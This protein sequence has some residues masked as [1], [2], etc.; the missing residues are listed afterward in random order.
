[1]SSPARKGRIIVTCGPSYEPIDQVR[2][3][4][5]LSTGKLGILLANRLA[6]SGWD[7]ACLK[8]EAATCPDALVGA[9]RITFSTNDDL[10]KR[11]TQLP[12]RN[13]VSAIFHSAALCDFK[14]KQVAGA[15]RSPETP[16]KHSSRSGEL[17]ITLEPATKLI[18][19]LRGLFPQARIV[20]WKYE[21]DGTR[22]DAVE[23]GWNQMAQNGTDACVVNGPA[24]GEG[25][26]VLERAGKGVV[27]LEDRVVLCEWLAGW[28][29]SKRWLEG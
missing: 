19:Q 28:V 18:G 4:T 27:H 26:G 9:E 5:N 1:M 15:E 7:V 24:Y 6:R 22:A 23:K 8:G 11:L 16:G 12:Y 10:L 29:R 3:I 21:V 25:F 17:T 13:E 14:V 20:G 2:R